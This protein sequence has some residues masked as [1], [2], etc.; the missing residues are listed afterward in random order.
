VAF[1][2]VCMSSMASDAQASI[3]VCPLLGLEF[4]TPV[5]AEIAGSV[6]PV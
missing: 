6:L 5:T 4:C 2:Y 3:A 1:I